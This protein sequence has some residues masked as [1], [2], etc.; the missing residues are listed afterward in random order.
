MLSGGREMVV[1]SVWRGKIGVAAAFEDDD[2]VVVCAATD[3]V[4][5][6]IQ[7]ST[8]IKEIWIKSGDLYLGFKRCGGCVLLLQ[9]SSQSSCVSRCRPSCLVQIP[10]SWRL[11]AGLL[12]YTSLA[13]I[14]CSLSSAGCDC[15]NLIEWV[16]F[17]ALSWK[18]VVNML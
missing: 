13:G 4:M 14:A 11:V 18:M 1:G 8:I 5:D 10:S 17:V 2:P 9:P 15:Y 3:D 7:S 12:R 16:G 6:S